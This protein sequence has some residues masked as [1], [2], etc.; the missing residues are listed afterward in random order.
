M[1]TNP[2][3]HHEVAIRIGADTWKDVIAALHHLSFIFDSEGPGHDLTS[4]GYSFGMVAVDKTNGDATHDSY[5]EEVE[6]WI[7]ARRKEKE[8]NA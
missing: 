7:E 1:S 6:A 3:R 8:Q 5:F 2:E 4:G